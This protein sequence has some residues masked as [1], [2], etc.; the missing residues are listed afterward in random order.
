MSQMHQADQLVAGGGAHQISQQC[1]L[2]KV[3]QNTQSPHPLVDGSCVDTSFWK[4]STCAAAACCA[5]E[6]TK[7]VNLTRCLLVVVRKM[8]QRSQQVGQ[9]SS[10]VPG[11]TAAAD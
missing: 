8:Q 1:V 5:E 7:L 10:S 4:A 6:C 9:G 3:M 11:Q 2:Y